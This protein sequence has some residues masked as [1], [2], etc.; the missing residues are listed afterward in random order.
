MLNLLRKYKRRRAVRH[1]GEKSACTEARV[2]SPR[3]GRLQ[4]LTF[5]ASEN[6]NLLVFVKSRMKTV[7]I[8]CLFLGV[9]LVVGQ[10]QNA[11]VP[12]LVRKVMEKQK[13]RPNWFNADPDVWPYAY[14]KR[15]T[16]TKFDSKGKVESKQTKKYDIVPITIPPLPFHYRH[17]TTLEIDGQ[18]VA[19]DKDEA[20]KA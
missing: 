14:E 5:D 19:K 3:I 12:E 10:S 15:V 4:L 13:D 16:N 2:P 9:S 6:P 18:S 11:G 20:R 1:Q 7:R 8:A 17:I